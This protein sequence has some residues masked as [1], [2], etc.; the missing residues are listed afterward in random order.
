MIVPLSN[1]L[2][3]DPRTMME[4][5]LPLFLAHLLGDFVF[6]TERMSY[7]KAHT[8]LWL[9]PHAAI[10]GCLTW[11]FCWQKRGG[12][13][14]AIVVFITHL[15]F[16]SVKARLPGNPLRWYLLDQA[17]HLAVLWF[18]A[19]WM[20]RHYNI[21]SMPLAEYIPLDIQLILCAYLSVFRPITFGLG[22]FLKPWM[23]EVAKVNGEDAA[24]PLTGLSRSGLWIGNLER[25]IALSC[26]LADQYL[27]IGAFIIA[28]SVL[29]IGDVSRPDQRKRA[30]Y[31][32]IGTF[33]S[34]GSAIVIGLLARW[35]M[36][37]W[38]VGHA[39]AI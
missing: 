38:L 8:I 14:V 17:G 33:A 20:V 19:Y 9:I 24:S 11:L 39:M 6:Q 28:K 34:A 21:I 31:I 26:V 22:L 32:I 23:G 12:M 25:L 37:N 16:D 2:L 35:I 10:V 4:V 30:D 18:C 29:R 15:V 13:E 27:V 7:R 5:F 1:S 3:F 36:E